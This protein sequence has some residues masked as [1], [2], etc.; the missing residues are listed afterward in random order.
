MS[1]IYKCET[2]NIAIKNRQNVGRHLKS[3]KHNNVSIN[4][5]EAKRKMIN[6]GLEIYIKF[7]N[8]LTKR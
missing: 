5:H 1:N 4:K 3:K 2:C 6:D 8:D 7:M